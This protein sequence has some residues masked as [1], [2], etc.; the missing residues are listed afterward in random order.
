MTLQQLLF[1]HNII[2]FL[3]MFS[4][5]LTLCPWMLRTQLIWSQGIL[6]LF[7]E[8]ITT[9]NVCIIYNHIIGTFLVRILLIAVSYYWIYQIQWTT[10]PVIIY[11]KVCGWLTVILL[12]YDIFFQKRLLL[13]NLCKRCLW[14][15]CKTMK[16]SSEKKRQQ[17]NRPF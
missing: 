2:V 15:L 17:L 8:F 3:K 13:Q 6:C 10:M 12:C 1:K 16:G 4:L 7:Q 11:L 5:S 14:I 9:Q